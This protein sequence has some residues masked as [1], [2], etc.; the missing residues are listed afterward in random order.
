M[1]GPVQSV[2]L[3]PLVPA[4]MADSA[5]Q[6]MAREGVTM[7]TDMLNNLI[8]NVSQCLVKFP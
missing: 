1:T 6:T 3:T 2:E 8:R 7:M 4:S 5:K